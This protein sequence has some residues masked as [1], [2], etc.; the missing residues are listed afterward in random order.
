M[1]FDLRQLRHVVT[2][3]QLR[4]FSRAA[5]ML[6]ITQPALSRSIAQF[7]AECGVRLFDR[8]RRGLTETFLGAGI[9]A[10]AQ[11][12]LAHAERFD[13]SMR[14][15]IDA[16][17]GSIALGAGPLAAELILPGLLSRFARERPAVQIE[18]VIDAASALFVQ[19]QRGRIELC[20][21]SRLVVPPDIDL[22]VRPT[23]DVRLAFLVRTGHPL[24]G[25]AGLSIADLAAYPIATGS[26][27]ND[28]FFQSDGGL[29]APA[30]TITCEN[31]TILEKVTRTSDAIWLS[32][33]DALM[34]GTPLLPL[35]VI[36]WRAARQ[37][38]CVV[39]PVGVTLSP[40]ARVVMAELVPAAKQS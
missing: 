6:N 1:R 18:T 40:L 25:R 13:L 12:L 2:V 5:G 37:D 21:V 10:E 26:K 33:P 30:T 28:I 4:S 27:G 23:A 9:I 8:N 36:E 15:R 34:Q 39:H 24:A 19:L 17:S 29:C 3:A 32:S 31:F 38:L 22:V 20:I 35:D 16:Q 7:E 11:G 14:R